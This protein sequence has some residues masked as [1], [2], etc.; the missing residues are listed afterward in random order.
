M[1]AEGVFQGDQCLKAALCRSPVNI[2]SSFP[3]AGPLCFARFSLG[4]PMTL[5]QSLPGCL[6]RCS[7]RAL[8]YAI[9]GLL[10][11]A[12]RWGYPNSQTDSA[13]LK[14]LVR[15]VVENELQVRARE[16]IFWRYMSQTQGEAESRTQI[17]VETREGTLKRLLAQNGRPL[18]PKQ[19]EQEDERIGDLIRNTRKL[20]KEK[21]EQN[22]D[23]QKAQSLF[24]MLPDAFLFTEESSDG[25][26][27]R[28]NLQPNP[29]FHPTTFESKLFRAVQGSMTVDV[30][31]KR[32]IEL[33]GSLSRDFELGWGLFGKLR[34]G[35]SLELRQEQ[36]EPG[37]WVVNF[38]DMQVTGRTWFFKTIGSR[39]H[40]LCWGFQR[41]PKDLSLQ[42]AAE[43]V[44]VK[45]PD[46]QH[47][48][49]TSQVRHQMVQRGNI[50]F[51]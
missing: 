9:V 2:D 20:D 19:L 28:L 48:K 25:Q 33:R 5:H 4:N 51:D 43:I 47:E 37:V 45:D 23:L 39:E 11:M 38:F 34:T 7:C 35:S 17:V 49:P 1:P 10:L 50:S 46:L 15:Q 26:K 24:K 29:N 31:Q 41:V 36:V 22:S 12:A 16:P 13:N 3:T 42:D 30:A 21:S 14:A 27:I 18:T 8:E 6:R 40:E 32:L 44:K